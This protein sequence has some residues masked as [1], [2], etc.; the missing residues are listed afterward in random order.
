MQRVA[1]VAAL[2]VGAAIGGGSYVFGASAPLLAGSIAVCYGAVVV[3]S[4]RYPDTVYDEEI[5]GGF[6]YGPWS[7]AATLFLLCVTVG[8]VGPLAIADGLRLSL[9]VLLLGVGYAM[10]LFGVGYA[11]AKTTA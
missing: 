11:R 7:A 4:A 8:T 2:V 5:V 10:W 3:L 9:A 6:R 1:W